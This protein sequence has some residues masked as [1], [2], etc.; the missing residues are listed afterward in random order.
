MENEVLFWFKRR[1]DL[2]VINFIDSPVFSEYFSAMTTL[3]SSAHWYL[4][5]HHLS[6][7]GLSALE[8]PYS[9]SSLI[10]LHCESTFGFWLSGRNQCIKTLAHN[11]ILRIKKKGILTQFKTSDSPLFIYHVFALLMQS[12]LFHTSLSL[13][14][15]FYWCLC[16]WVNFDHYSADYILWSD[17]AWMPL[18]VTLVS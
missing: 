13:L 5:Y 7:E 2:E 11:R 1:N 17:G 3:I 8:F 10:W 18:K 15:I 4:A 6:N 12:G 14:P 9:H 16:N